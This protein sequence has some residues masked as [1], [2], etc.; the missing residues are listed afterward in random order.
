MILIDI[1]AYA[2]NAVY[3]FHLDESVPVSSVLEEI[4]E[5]ITQCEQCVSVKCHE[6]MLLFTQD[7]R[8]LP[9][10]LTLN[11]SGIKTGDR[12]ILI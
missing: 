5:I 9:S 11:Q 8:L 10:N 7:G 2:F 1:E 12:L 6:N 4:D 3:D